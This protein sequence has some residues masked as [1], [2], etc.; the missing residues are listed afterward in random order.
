VGQYERVLGL[1]RIFHLKGF[2]NGTELLL[3]DVV[4]LMGQYLGILES[5]VPFK[6]MEN[7]HDAEADEL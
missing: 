2:N 3:A 1:D 5:K 6:V 4:S 7:T